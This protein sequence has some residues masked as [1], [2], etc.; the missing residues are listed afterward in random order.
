MVRDKTFVVSVRIMDPV[1]SLLT[2]ARN[3]DIGKVTG[4]LGCGTS[5][6]KDRVCII[7]F[8]IQKHEN[9]IAYFNW[10]DSQFGNTP[11]HLA[12]EN[13]HYA[14]CELLIKSCYSPSRDTASKSGK[15]VYSSHYLINY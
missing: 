15:Y 8:S 13:N 1:K 4:L 7:A 3:G 9:R 5:T 11:L 6:A 14:T 10:F 12:A 2:H